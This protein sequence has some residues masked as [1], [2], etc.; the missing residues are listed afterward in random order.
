MTDAME[1]T[2]AAL[3]I[4]KVPAEW[5]DAAYFSKKTLQEW[6]ADLLLRVQQLVEWTDDLE[7]PAVLWIAGLFNPMSFLTAIMQVTS[8]AHQLPLDDIC[9]KTEVRNSY[10]KEDFKTAETGAYVNG[11]FLEG[12]AW[13]VARG[14]E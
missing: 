6:F 7:T 13:E 4:N 11:F 8:R 10:S 12:A 5:A 3:R 2:A 9:L 14:D 1:A